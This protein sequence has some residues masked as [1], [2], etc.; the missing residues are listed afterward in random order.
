MKKKISVI[1]ALSSLMLRV[2]GAEAMPRI[3][4]MAKKLVAF[5]KFDNS[6]EGL[7]KKTIA[8]AL[9]CVLT[10]SV[11]A[12]GTVAW[13][14]DQS[15]TAQNSFTFGNIDIN[16]TETGAV[17]GKQTL[18]VNPGTKVAKDPKVTV[19]PNSEDSYVYVKV[20]EDITLDG[21]T[22]TPE[23]KDFFQY[24]IADGWTEIGDTGIYYRE[25]DKTNTATEYY[26]IEGEGSGEFKNGFVQGNPKVTNEDVDA[27]SAHW[28]TLT[29]KAY[30]VQK[31][32]ASNAEDAWL[33][34][35][36]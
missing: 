22:E 8:L 23:F 18:K 35:F 32:I 2:L 6:R 15:E 7:K 21:A 36:A 19:T 13:F 26:I 9:S 30:A 16:L 4:S 20:T 11:F 14:N 28:P 33:K 17:E 3:R 27:M 5:F 31:G 24:E 1:V 25:H 34:A 12:V 29:F 10:I